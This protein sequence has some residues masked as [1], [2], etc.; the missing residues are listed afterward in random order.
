[1]VGTFRNFVLS[2]VSHTDKIF[3]EFVWFFFQ[4][5]LRIYR[6]GVS[7][8]LMPLLLEVWNLSL[9]NTQ[10]F[11]SGESFCPIHLVTQEKCE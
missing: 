8:W 9:N 4:K 5:K 1:M 7:T 10:K 6:V 3:L 2:Y 11:F